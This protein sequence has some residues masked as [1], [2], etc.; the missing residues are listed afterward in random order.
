M[1][2]GELRQA[3]RNRMAV[4]IPA[5]SAVNLHQRFSVPFAAVV[6]ALIGVPLGLRRQLDRLFAWPGRAY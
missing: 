5:A 1:P 3:I 6:F 2:V 4:G